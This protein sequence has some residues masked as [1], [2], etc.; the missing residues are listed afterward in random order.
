MAKAVKLVWRN[1][2]N[3]IQRLYMK[4]LIKNSIV[5]ALALAMATFGTSNAR[6]WRCGWPIAAGVFGGLAVGTAIGATVAN[7]SA[8]AC[9]YPAYSYPV[10]RTYQTY[11]AYP[12]PGYN[13]AAPA[14]QPVVQTVTPSPVYVQQP[15]PVYYYSSP[16][17]YAAPYPYVYPYVRFGW[18]YPRHVVYRRR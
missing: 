14:V 17:V 11:P 10:Y 15:A 3:D 4:T 18:G 7:A 13:T 1:R 12:A 16:V 9:V 5:A 8:P 6:A 2:N